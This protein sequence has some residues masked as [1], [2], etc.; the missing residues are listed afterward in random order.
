[1]SYGYGFVP[2]TRGA[3]SMP[4]VP[5]HRLPVVAKPQPLPPIVVSPFGVEFTYGEDGARLPTIANILSEVALRHG[6]T[7]AQLKS[8]CRAR[9]VIVA[10][11]EA[12]WRC[13][14]EKRWSLKQI[15]RALNRDHST[16]LHGVRAHEKRREAVA[17]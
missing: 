11:Q 8:D 16:I 17:A 9:D 3:P 13:H 7:V 12:M 1:M 4:V 15:G 14:G 6:V 2:K 5:R 10:R